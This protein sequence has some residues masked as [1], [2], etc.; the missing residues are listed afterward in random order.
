[1]SDEE[2]AKLA[3]AIAKIVDENEARRETRAKVAALE[4]AVVDYGEAKKRWESAW[5]ALRDDTCAVR[6]D[7]FADL[8][9]PWISNRNH[10]VY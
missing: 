6:P 10:Y 1:M 4:N 9:P 7:G 8:C 2:I 3:Q 5:L